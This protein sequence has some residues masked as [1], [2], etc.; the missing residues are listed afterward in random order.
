MEF[1]KF[2]YAIQLANQLALAGLR[3]AS[4]LDSVMEFG[5]N[6]IDDVINVVTNRPN[7]HHTPS[8]SRT[9]AMIFLPAGD[10]YNRSSKFNAVRTGELLGGFKVCGSC[11]VE[12]GS[13]LVLRQQYT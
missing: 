4:E 7:H 9:A 3:S 13:F 2:H 12:L 6:L 11:D 1:A 5:L 8:A 10:C